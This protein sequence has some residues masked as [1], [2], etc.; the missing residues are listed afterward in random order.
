M[1]WGI[2]PNAPAKEQIKSEFEGIIRGLDCVGEIDY[3]TYSKLFDE[4]MPLFDKMHE[5]GKK[6]AVT[7]HKYPDEVPQR[8][9][10]FLVTIQSPTG[11]IFVDVLFY[12][13]FAKSWMD[14]N[15]LDQVLAWAELP[16]PYK[17]E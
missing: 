4:I 8:F 12:S 11:A 17:P 10:K 16:E 9:D 5:Q 3:L 6:D 1:L 7:W 14:L 15:I 2:S 13:D